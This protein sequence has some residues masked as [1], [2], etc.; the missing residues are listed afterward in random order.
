MLAS[1]FEEIKMQRRVKNRTIEKIVITA[2][3]A[4]IYVAL[5]AISSAFGLAFSVVQFR[6]SEVL[7]V[8]PVFSPYAVAGLTLGCFI[9]NLASPFGIFDMIFGTLSTLIAAYLTRKLS[10]VTFKN[11]PI[12]ALLPPV[13]VGA[14]IVGAMIAFLLPEGFSAYAFIFSAMS[15][16]IGQFVVCYGLGI[17]LFFLIRKLQI[18]KDK[19]S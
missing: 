1:K 9:S 3:I 6:L 15:V 2:T 5:T 14:V 19:Q 8:L 7:T 17:P 11:I 4:A 13:L 18:F 16:G 12:L 10:C